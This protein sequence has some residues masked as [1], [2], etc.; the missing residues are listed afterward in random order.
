M[1]VIRDYDSY[2]RHLA[3][4]PSTPPPPSSLPSPDTRTR[5]PQTPFRIITEFH[6]V[7]SDQSPDPSNIIYHIIKTGGF[8]LL[9]LL[10][11]S[12]NKQTVNLHLHSPFTHHNTVATHPQ[13]WNHPCLSWSINRGKTSPRHPQPA[14]LPWYR[15]HRRGSHDCSEGS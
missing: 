7:G 10:Q 14:Q 12:F 13:T 1:K 9:I 5:R 6:T 8:P 3:R 2:I 15:S 11:H 4:Q